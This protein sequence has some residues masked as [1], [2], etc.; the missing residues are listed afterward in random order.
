[1]TITGSHRC[2]APIDPYPTGPPILSIPPSIVGA[3]SV[4][5]LLAAVPGTWEGGK[6]LR[7]SYAWSRCDAAGANCIAIAGATRE[8]YIPVSA[9]VGH[10]LVVVTTAT[11]AGL[12][13][14]AASAPSA[15][16]TPAGTPPAA[17]PVNI[18]PPQIVGKAQ[19]GQMLTTSVGT[20]TGSPKKFAYRWRRGTAPATS[21]IAIPRAIQPGYTLTPDDIGSTLSLVVT[22][23]GAGGS[24]SATAATTGVVV[25]APLPAVSI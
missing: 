11:S 10:S 23:T 25:A 21:C 13:A 14:T 6:P 24:T 8:T 3:P 20:W 19:A 16:V 17:R 18:G 2:S 1:D 22:G 7:F 15:T 12:S 5:V 4:G 9:D